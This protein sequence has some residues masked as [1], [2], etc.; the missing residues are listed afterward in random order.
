MV[1]IPRDLVLL[2]KSIVLTADI[3]FVNGWPFL[4]TRSR[5]VQLIIITVEYLPNRTAKV[6]GLYLTRVL[7]LYGR[8]GFSVQVALMDREFAAVQEECPELPINPTAA[9]EHVPEP[10]R[11]IRLVKERARGVENTLP[12]EGLPKVMVIELIHFIVLWLN[13]FP[14]KSGVSTKYSP[15]ELICR[16]KLDAKVHCKTPF[17]TYCETHEEPNPKNGMK[18]RTTPSICLGPTGNIQGSY[19][20]YCLKT[21]KKIVRRAW[22]EL[23]MPK[24]VIDRVNKH[25]KRD[26][27]TAKLTFAD[28]NNKIFEFSNEEYDKP[29]LVEPEPSPYPDMI[30]SEFP[31]VPLESHYAEATEAIETP[32]EPPIGQLMQEA[33][34]NAGM[35]PGMDPEGDDE[36]AQLVEADD[37]EIEELL[38]DD[39]EGIIEIQDGLPHAPEPAQIVEVEDVTE[40][41]EEPV[42]NEGADFEPDEPEDEGAATVRRSSRN[43]RVSSMLKD[44]VHEA[45]KILQ[46]SEN[47]FTMYDKDGAEEGVDEYMHSMLDEDKCDEIDSY[48]TPVFE[49]IITQYAVKSGLEK[50][51]NANKE[52][53]EKL[54]N[55]ICMTQY[56]LKAGLKKFGAEGEKAVTKELSQFHDMSV[57]EP[58]DATTLSPDDKKKAL[59][60]LLFLKEKRDGRIK[61]RACADGR[62][63]RE[64]KRDN[65][66]GRSSLTYSIHRFSFP[67]MRN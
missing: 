23:P 1:T 4:L 14:V 20:F 27:A 8:A 58:V 11:A 34:A 19:K 44:T 30:P 42:M 13:N 56:S 49:H 5:R 32:P 65:S 25:A 50:I 51:K 66:P 7:Q 59:A 6:I 63:Q 24:L 18:P 36:G 31:G 46:P 10:E 29:P 60:S 41:E 28:R 47:I 53:L 62:K 43:R 45:E 54:V 17:G 37:G 2:H 3:M 57:F 64:T 39:D 52:E 48:L 40:E 35:N 55:E 21:G 33:A 61:A 67:D 16:H 9:N 26:K 12:F 22:D 15:R 38:E